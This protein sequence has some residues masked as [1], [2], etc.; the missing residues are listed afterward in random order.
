MG[1]IMSL[2]ADI[3][4]IF[5]DNTSYMNPGQAVNQASSLN[6]LSA[7]LYTDSKRFIYE[8]LQNADDSS[9]NNDG[10]KVW[11]KIFG[12]NL[13]IAHSGTP[14]T[15]RDLQGICN[16]N[17][18]TKKS[19]LTKTGYK[20]IGFKS[21]FGQSDKVTIYTKDEYFR[22]DASYSFEWK[23]EESKITWENN[24]DRKFQF[25]WQIIPIY[26]EEKEVLESINQFLSKN[27]A[28]VATI[29]QMKN[30][31]ETSLAGQNL[32]QNLNMFLFLK[33]I[34]EINFDVSES[35]IV[36]IDRT[37]M[38]RITLQ[39]GNN[40]K[41][42]WLVNTVSLI[43]PNEVKAVLQDERNIPE[44]LLNT[45][46]IELCLAAKIGNDGITKLSNQEKLLYSYLPTDET[47][48]SLPV[49][50]NTS[51]L[52]AANR[53]SLHADSKWN[54]WLF[55]SIAIEIFKWISKLVNT[56]YHFQ[57]Y[58]LIPRE[59]IS[60]ELGKKFNDGI[61][62]ALKSVPFVVS[63]KDQLIK[64]E[65]TIV[66]FTYLSEKYFIGEEPIKNFINANKT[67]YPKQFAK[68]S[69]F[70]SELKRLGASC[71]EWI[72][73]QRFITSPY[74]K[75][76]HTIAYNIELIKHL[77]E[78]CE[79]EKATEISTD[80]L[81]K[82]PFIWDHKN[83]I[84][85]PHQ[86]CFPTAD[87]QNWDN[88]NSELSFL[89]KELQNWLLKDIEFRHWLES[90]GVREKTDITYIT[91]NIIP[92][93]ESY[94][95]PQNALKTIRD[96]F[97]LYKKGDLRE[98]LIGKLS[99][100]RLIT[101]RGSLC[102]AEDCFL[103]NFYKSRMEIEEIIEN[104]IFVS[105][106]YCLDSLEKDEWKRFFKLMGVHEGIEA[107]QYRNKLHRTALNDCGL[108]DNYFETDNKK[109][110][111]AF[112]TFRADYFSDIAIMTYIQLTENNIK[113]AFKFWTDY[114]ENYPPSIIK[115]PAVAYWGYEGR[116]GRTSGDQVENYVPW[117]I[118]NI[119]CI[120]TVLEKCEIAPSVLLNTTEIKAIVGKYLPVFDGPELVPDWKAFFN[121]RTRL[122]LV[123]YL[124]LLV[125]ISLDIDEK[126]SSRSNNYKRIQS[127]YSSLLAQCINWSSDDI[128]EVQ[129][130][131]N[132]GFLLNTKS[133]FTKCTSL[134]YFLDGNEAVFQEQYCFIQLSAENKNN[135]NLEKLLSYFKVQ[136]LKQSEFE[137]IHTQEESCITLM[138]KLKA[139]VPYFQIWINSEDSNDT[140]KDSLENLEHKVDELKLFQA[141]ELKI[142]YS[143]IDFVKNVNIHF[144][145]TSL[146]VTIP[147][148]S[149]SVLLKL[150][151]VLCRYFHLV[152]HEKKL[153]FLLRS[154]ADEIQKYFLQEEFYIPEDVL[155]IKYNFDVDSEN[156]KV[157]S[158][159]DIEMAIKEKKI[160]VEF[161]HMTK[162]DYSR[163]EYIEERI[164]RAVNNVIKHLKGLPEYDCSNIDGIAKSVISGITKNGNEITVVARPSDNDKVLIFYSSEFDVLEYVDAE[165]WCEDGITPPKQI[166]LGQL[167]KLTGINRIPIKN[168]DVENAELQILMNQPKSE[169]LD[170]NA[171]PYGAQKIAKII[172][173]FANTNG[174]TLIF[175]IK[176]ISPISNL[177]VGLS[178]DFYIANTTKKAISMLSPIPIVTY[179]WVNN[180]GESVF[181]IK[182]E[183][184][185]KD[186]LLDSQKYIRE[187]CN[188]VLEKKISESS[189]KL[190][191]TSYRKTIAIIIAIE[192]YA[193]REDNQVQKVKYAR[194]DAY[195]F[196]D[197]LMKSM[198]LDEND[199]Y[200]YVD[201]NAL[202]SSLEYDFTGL[203]HL[204]T[205]DDRLVFYYVGHGFHNGITN[206]LSTYDMHPLHISET[207]VS[208]RKIL[209]DPLLA[210]K[211]KNALIFIDACA[212]SFKD[213][214]GRRQ[215]T[216][217]DDE[218]IILLTD[219]FPCYA[220]F[221]SCQPGQS[222]YS[223]DILSNGIWTYHLIKALSGGISEVLYENKYITDRSLK[224]YL[225]SSVYE[226][227]KDKLGFNQNP[228]AILDS[229]HENV[230]V[231]IKKEYA[232][233]F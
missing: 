93:I 159:A 202:K 211:C 144:N 66:D 127:I 94:V 161:Y 201:D 55:K 21:V 203:F 108:N 150:S 43:V 64:I 39:K 221:L 13:V 99:K 46:S 184:S 10:V 30:A 28:N 120:P 82:L 119:K 152:G 165:L 193:I 229:S 17:N 101:Q 110:T 219:E 171:I 16:I 9:P 2:K 173:A 214:N 79:S 5:I 182:T 100:I 8:L 204:L 206:F 227:A 40:S 4:K 92:R 117:F 149:N 115:A 34:C 139:I 216:D 50:V 143:G 103:S 14:F 215:I 81:V 186:I 3:E 118:K 126:G 156:H 112:S 185:D 196:K 217:I 125:K 129:N 128:E 36:K 74:F 232:Q 166:T 87:D 164:P 224:E 231:E 172:S 175:G 86:V 27:K 170:F 19:D 137:L 136:I 60:D 90:L 230:I 134:K 197:V 45:D 155:E 84:N 198:G 71:F 167:L 111:P 146:F 44:K 194:N 157:S 220:T 140:T 113:F 109:F 154:S 12:N 163:R 23:W 78:L 189:T 142:T 20:G 38:D 176:E 25:P 168:I 205:E 174:G 68:K 42:D 72:H 56:E 102:P 96:L 223:C 88:T 18:G 104:D 65:E 24:N 80:V 53:E 62:E 76:T 22:F 130:W 83:H 207:A 210:S 97:S 213:E 181:I 75:D 148:N 63:R 200:M 89:H 190:S 153:D 191:I 160:S 57:A 131:A 178:S 132:N 77:K 35:T 199:I 179:D 124:E 41:V 169:V 192:N 70:F 212:Q 33:N 141:E 59:T 29:I 7:D 208:L 135:P 145:D 85:Y 162:H 106:T 226:Y 61:K 52:T 147:W 98:G 37:K 228:K 73:L 233:Q 15:A 133:Q 188:S 222:S 1:D 51:F 209:I 138:N 95:T 48:Y 180:G 31:T 114:I 183:K 26:T 116:P 69:S 6:A 47:K 195:R 32:S 91:H 121:F 177:V 105:E 67:V 218:E 122:E 11:I 187:E 158:F 123:D 151:D 225:S 58:Q 107:I 54:Q 49:L